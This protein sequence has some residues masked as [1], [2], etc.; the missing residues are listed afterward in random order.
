MAAQIIISS[1]SKHFLTILTV[2]LTL[3]SLARHTS[4]ASKKVPLSSSQAFIKKSC[5]TTTYPSLCIKTL[6][7]Y[8]PSVGT[9]RFKL[10]NA[11]LSAAIKAAGN[12]SAAVSKLSSTQK[13][14]A[15]P[16][17][18]AIKECIGD[19]KDAVYELKQTVAAMGRLGK[20]ADRDF[21]WAN[22]KTY[23]SAAITDAETC[24]DGFLGRKV[25]PVVRRKIR[26]CVVG[27]EKLISNALSLI[28]RLY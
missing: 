16:E 5:N 12:C 10:C 26:S 4:A 9:S 19:L 22:A 27:V 7:P 2:F 23:A 3:T 28:N 8:A 17:A 14:I 20:G 24:V 21:Q 18:R 1:C 6:T 15:R 25:N 13:G 11:A